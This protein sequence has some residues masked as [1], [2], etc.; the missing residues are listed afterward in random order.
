MKTIHLVHYDKPDK[1]SILIERRRY[2]VQLGNGTKKIFKG[3]RA[4]RKY[5]AD[6]NRFLT[7]KLHE[8]NLIYCDVHR[9]YRMAWFYLDGSYQD[10]MK[11]KDSLRSTEEVFNLMVERA[12][13]ENGNHFVFSH[14]RA[15]EQY[16]KE[17][18]SVLKEIYHRL[19]HHS[20]V[21][22]L[23]CILQRIIYTSAEI[24]NYI[25]PK[26]SERIEKQ[27]EPLL[28]AVK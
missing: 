2:V 10:E 18:L 20:I 14:F 6:T 13:F 16:L 1:T 8:Y 17:I 11:I 5:I 24:D 21:Y 9:L 7:F 26:K 27:E 23:E 12:H 4:C 28:R 25:L 15:I 3:G 22:D 19:N